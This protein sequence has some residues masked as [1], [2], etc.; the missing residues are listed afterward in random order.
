MVLFYHYV[1]LMVD[2]ILIVL[3]LIVVTVVIIM[4]EYYN[5]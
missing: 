5:D 1:S 4:T 2:M 3:I